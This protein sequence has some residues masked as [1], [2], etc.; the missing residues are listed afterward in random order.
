MWGRI[1]RGKRESGSYIFVSYILRLLGRTSNGEEGKG[2]K[3]FGK[4]MKIKKVGMGKNI[5]LWGTIYTPV[6]T[7]SQ[8]ISAQSLVLSTTRRVPV[9]RITSLDRI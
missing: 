8:T 7:F 3:N 6:I 4:K 2:P 9:V 5:K 1:K